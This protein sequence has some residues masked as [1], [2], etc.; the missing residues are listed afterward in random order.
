MK[1]AFFALVSLV[2]LTAT[3][4]A[5][6][7][8]R[9]APQP[10]YKAPAMA[11]AYSWTGFYIGVNGGGGFGRSVWDT[12]TGFN[13]SGG[14][15][16]GTVGYNYQVGQA[17]VGIEGDIDW[18]NING[19]TNTGCPAGCKTSDNWL[20]TVRGRLGY[21][22]DRFMPYITGGVAFGDIKATTPGFV[23]ANNSQAGW[24]LGAGLEFALAQNWTAKAEYLYVD[25][26]KF[27]CGLSCSAFP[28]DNVAFTT[29]LVRAGINYR[30]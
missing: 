24:T 11:P 26:G 28:T 15:V 10:Y 5:A 4:A 6:D 1:R 25:L 13:T 21:A 2:A 9:P 30:F 16:G 8:G 29:N 3:A 7:L 20:S 23:G 19:T 12:T 22:A 18:A 14:L 17:V 27:N